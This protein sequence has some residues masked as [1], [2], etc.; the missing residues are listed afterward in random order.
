MNANTLVPSDNQRA[1]IS[2]YVD[3]IV[4]SIR[5]EIPYTMNSSQ[6]GCSCL[7]H[8]SP[9]SFPYITVVTKH[10]CT[11]CFI[12]IIPIRSYAA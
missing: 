5:N 8:M 11:V 1:R 10:F 12:R 9:D 2:S 3:E 7:A 4:K 6:T